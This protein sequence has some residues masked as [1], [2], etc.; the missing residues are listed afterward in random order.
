MHETVEEGVQ[1]AS[2]VKT[3]RSFFHKSMLIEN[4]NIRL[5]TVLIVGLAAPLARVTE[6][7]VDAVTAGETAI[8]PKFLLT[9]MI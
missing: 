7:E 5:S 3:I 6:S 1:D 8:N 2:G 4:L 9:S